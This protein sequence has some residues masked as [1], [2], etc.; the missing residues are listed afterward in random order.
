MLFEC[1]TGRQAFRGDTVTDTL[2]AILKSEPDWDRLPP[3]TPERVRVLLRRCLEKDPARRLHD[4]ADARI[5]IED[6]LAQPQVAPAPTMP[7]RGSR[8][9][10][11]LWGAAGLI[12]E[13]SPPC[14]R[15]VP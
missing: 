3:E 9:R 8:R 1:L 6:T 10:S 13:R 7:G 12:A 5:E 11:F 14:S 2:A 15:Y 4:I